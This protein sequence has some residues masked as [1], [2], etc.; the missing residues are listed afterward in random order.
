MNKLDLST[1]KIGDV[2]EVLFPNEQRPRD[3]FMGMIIEHYGT[4]LTLRNIA[5]NLEE[6][7]PV[8]TLDRRGHSNTESVSQK[9]L[10]MPQLRVGRRVLRP[11]PQ[12]RRWADNAEALLSFNDEQNDAV[13]TGLSLDALLRH[14]S[15]KFILGVH[16][17]RGGELR[18][19]AT[20][21]EPF[22][23]FTSNRIVRQHVT[24]FELEGDAEMVKNG[25]DRE[26]R[27]L[28]PDTAQYHVLETGPVIAGNDGTLRVGDSGNHRHY[29]LFRAKHFAVETK[30]LKLAGI[31]A[32]P[33]TA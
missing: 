30:A 15:C 2:C 1:L 16:P 18:Q 9:S 13:P 4:Q 20:F 14:E 5:V 12:F 7:A 8:P 33:S 3:G 26:Y 29:D 10:E 28:L 22:Y 19:T 24:V 6:N 27:L 31:P 25:R 17:K 23:D 21:R 32:E 11:Y